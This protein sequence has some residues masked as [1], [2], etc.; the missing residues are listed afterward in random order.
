MAENDPYDEE[1]E[2]ELKK[3]S[4]GRQVWK[5]YYFI[6]LGGSL[7]Y[8]K[9]S[10]NKPEGDFHLKGAKIEDKV[11]DS[12]RPTSFSIKNGDGVLILAAGSPEEKETWIKALKANLDKP[13]TSAPER[14]QTKKS[15]AYRAK[16]SIS[17][18][19]ATSGAGRAVIREIVPEAVLTVL[20]CVKRFV[21]KVDSAEK[22][23]QLEKDIV[24]IGTK[25]ILLFKEK[26]IAAK[27]FLALE[28]PL[29]NVCSMIID[30]HE[31]SFSFDE[32]KLADAF[33]DLRGL[34]EKLLKNHL[35]PKNLD[36]IKAIFD[37]TKPEILLK[38]FND[39]NKELPVV[40]GLLREAWDKKR[41]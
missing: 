35:S 14:K 6:L 8:Y 21:E 16:N 22:A 38:F 34:I 41:I 1:G 37:Y 11:E 12:S 9:K 24:R 5:E 39:E 27:E 19:V 4:M 3:K 18:K 25:V 2:L 7:F 33:A 23:T 20:D 10:E 30:G 26:K 17:S 31:I 29:R 13:K 28:K 32:N 36:K 15:L 40:A